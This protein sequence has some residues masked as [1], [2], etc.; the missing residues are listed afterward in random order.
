MTP[1][2]RRQTRQVMGGLE[3]GSYWD[4]GGP[5]DVD[6]GEVFSASLMYPASI[7]FFSATRW[8]RAATSSTLP[9]ESSEEIMVPT[10]VPID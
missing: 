1:R 6:V 7:I 3:I 10:T 9:A 8:A 4:G 5:L 2:E